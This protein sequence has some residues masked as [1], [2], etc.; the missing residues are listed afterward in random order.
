MAG[1]YFSFSRLCWSAID[2]YTRQD[3]FTENYLTSQKP[4]VFSEVG[5]LIYVFDIESREFDQDLKT[6]SA[7]IKALQEYSP[8]AAVFSLIHK[9]D[10]VQADFRAKLLQ[11]R[12]D[13]IREKSE[14]F[15][16]TV[17]TYATS[18]WDETLY[19]AWGMIVHSLVPNLDTIERYL[20]HMMDVINAEEVILFEQATFLT[21]TSVT[22]KIGDRNPYYDRYER[23]SNII[24][25][26]K[27]SLA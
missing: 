25:T 27:H 1:K 2:R 26:F 22:S 12:S 19:K 5:V 11:E 4:Y 18:I 6:Y 13:M 8:R 20:S 14:C 21:V 24:K 15:E 9:M 17:Q 23:L 10:L 3:A 7:V 16:R